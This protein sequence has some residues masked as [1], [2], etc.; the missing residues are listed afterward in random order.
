MRSLTWGQDSNRVPKTLELKALNAPSDLTVTRR[1]DTYNLFK[2]ISV[3]AHVSRF[4]SI[5][6]SQ[7]L[8]RLVSF[9]PAAIAGSLMPSGRALPQNAHDLQDC[10]DMLLLPHSLPAFLRR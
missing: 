1:V 9:M 7:I 8:H 3:D 4:L 6:T 5:A 10:F 2:W